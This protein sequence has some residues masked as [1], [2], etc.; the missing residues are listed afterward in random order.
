MREM[1][2]CADDSVVTWL[3]TSRDSSILA[4]G[5]RLADCMASQSVRDAR[6]WEVID[7]RP[8]IREETRT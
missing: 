3:H 5:G 7:Y 6:T 2:R 4:G 8:L 1:M